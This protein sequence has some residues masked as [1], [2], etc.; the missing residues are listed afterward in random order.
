MLALV[1]AGGVATA[2]ASSSQSRAETFGLATSA[3]VAQAIESGG[4]ISDPQLT[5]PAVAEELPRSDIG[6][7]EA[8]DLLEGVFE[9][10]LDQFNGEAEGGEAE[11][12]LSPTVALVPSEEDQPATQSSPPPSGSGPE[13]PEEVDAETQRAAEKVLISEGKPPSAANAVAGV[14][15][16]ADEIGPVLAESAL[17]QSTVPLRAEG[18]T[19]HQEA[20]DLS[21]EHSSGELQPANPLVEVGVPDDLA[22][23]VQLG[24]AGVQIE[25]ADAPTGRAPSTVDDSVAFYPNVAPDT[26]FAVVPT[27]T[28]VE[29]LT[30]L[31]SSDAPRSQTLEL[32]L[33]AGAK[34]EATED[35]GAAVVTGEDTLVGVQAPTALDAGGESVPVSLEVSGDSLVLTVSPD[36]STSFPVLV[37]PLFQTYEW[38][39]EGTKT[40]QDGICSSSIEYHSYNPCN[41]REEWGSEGYSHAWPPPIK[42]DVQFWGTA[43]LYVEQGTPGLFIRSTDMLT[44]GDQG[45]WLYTVPRYFTDQENYGGATP[46]S[47]ISKMTLSNVLW[48]AF[49]AHP[50]PYLYMGLWSPNKSQWVSYYTH[51]GGAGHSVSDMAHPYEFTSGTWNGEQVTNQNTDAKVGYV[52][53]RATETQS[54]Q[55]TDVYVGSAAIRLED[56]DVPQQPIA[57]GPSQWVNQAASQIGFTAADTGLGVSSVTASTEQLGSNGQPLHSWKATYG[58]LGVADA[59]CPRKWLSSEA[60]HPALKVEPALL[61]AGEDFLNVVVEDPVGNKSSAASALVR[62]D[63]TAPTVSI[64]GT[65]TEQATLGTKRPA[66]MVKVNA[67]DGT[68]AASQSGAAKIAIQ[69]DGS[70]VKQSE[71][72][73][74]TQNCSLGLEWAI[75]SSKYVAGEHSIKVIATDAVGISTSEERKVTLKPSPPELSLS[76][77]M[78]EQASLGTTRPRYV[79]NVVAASQAGEPVAALTPSYLSSFGSYGT[80][81]GQFGHPADVAVDSSGSLWVVDEG[82]NRLQV[83][84]AKGEFVKSIGSSGSGNGQFRTPKSIA[85]AADG[86]FWVADSENSRLEKFSASG[87]FVKAVGSLG[88]GN[89]QF[90]RPEGI[91]IDAKGNIWVTDTYNYRVQELNSAGEFI[92][93]VNP[94]GLGA[95]EPT[96]IDA[97]PG[98]NVWVADWANN[99]VVEFNEAGGLVRS[100]GTQGTGNGQFNQPDAITIDSGGTVWV[101]DQNNGRIQGFN[102]SGEYLTQFGSKGAGAGQFT[103]S[104]PIGMAADAQGNLWIT[105]TNNNRVQRWVVPGSVPIYSS[106]LGASGTGNGQFSIPSGVAVGAE[107][108]LFVADTGNDR[109]EEFNQNGE[110]VKKFGSGQLNEPSAVAIAPSGHLWVSDTAG[111]RVVE[112]NEEGQ[113]LSSFTGTGAN[114]L[115]EPHGLAVDP[116]GKIWVVDT[117]SNRVEEFS[118]QGVLL[119]AFKGSGSLFWPTSIAAGPDGTIW[120]ADPIT[121]AVEKLGSDGSFKGQ[122]AA[123][124]GGFSNPSDIAVDESGEVW[125]AEYGSGG[126]D[127]FSSGGAFAGHFGAGGSGPGQFS[128]EVFRGGLAV[129]ARGNLWVGDTGNNR[130]QKW[131][132][133][134]SSAQVSTEVF[135][136]GKRVQAAAAGCTSEHCPIAKQWT[137]EAPGNEGSHTVLVKATDGLGN[138]NSK[139]LSIGVQK[140]TTKPTIEAGGSLI[141]APEGW[142]EQDG[143]GVNALAKDAGSGATSI[144]LKIDGKQAAATTPLD[145]PD[146]GCEAHLQQTINMAAY[147]G[148]AHP[149]EV[150][151][152]D[153]AGNTTVQNW[154]I[155][156]DPEGHISAAEAEDTLEAADGTSG[157]TVV[158]PTAES[159]SAEERADGNNPSLEN[160]GDQLESSGAADPS[161]IAKDPDEGFTV[162]LPDTSISATPVKVN[163]GATEMVVAANSAAIS[164]NTTP[165]VDAVVRP[166][167]NGVTTFQSIRNVS[168]PETFSWEVDLASGQTLKSLDPLDAGVFYAGGHEA[169]VISA[170]LAHDAVGTTVPTTISVSSGNTVT[171]TVEHQSGAFV[172]PVVGG[173]GWEGGFTTAIVAGPKDEQELREER[174]RIEQELR[175]Q[176]E[177]EW[178]HEAEAGS[179]DEPP[180]EGL[181]DIDPKEPHRPHLMRTIVDA[182]VLLDWSTRKRRS[183]ATTS[184][185]SQVSCDY[186]HAWEVGT[187]FWNGQEHVVGGFAW[188]GDTT[189]RCYTSDGPLFGSGPIR[190]GWAGP[191]PAPYG[192]GAHLNLWCN[193]HVSWFNITEIVDNHYN[194]QDH[195]Y[196]DGYQ[197]QHI[198]KYDPLLNP[199]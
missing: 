39:K 190:I 104:Y 80:G 187:W 38:M 15:V 143:Y 30:Q 168:A 54:T 134:G 195:L 55:N 150:I 51:E 61:P 96:G 90:N 129:D 176:A 28:G 72:G 74:S 13:A 148:G 149:A 64:S 49:S 191:N 193:F 57:T 23:G 182:P 88:S 56:K 46:T 95:I 29:T 35:G 99:R 159:I 44:A 89:G 91:A 122:L 198:H 153:G 180:G 32:D 41:N 167:Y 165:N 142:V 60:G 2:L 47:Y 186:W 6:R 3:D 36:S 12:Y 37:D 173:T 199:E 124:P 117:W 26:D 119:G 154:T 10:V 112:Y 69:F 100:F 73:C 94:S 172:Y 63:H 68:S 62:V 151:A 114:K 141:N 164:G 106:S 113:L 128:F 93:V 92:K 192:Y 77:T 105:D 156:V 75:E 65:A 118:P 22:E 162:A 45:N 126:I 97:G 196:G 78:S 5:N 84:N 20:V 177:R 110:F 53:I 9:P 127:R 123:P 116:S 58:C 11:R 140:D 147:D 70:A 109:I 33:P 25:L 16:S 185:C 50:S 40:W 31:R 48:Q 83:V 18:S 189:S 145:C 132:V 194:M 152:K 139:S 52:G 66:Y 71:P 144:E 42:P 8:L 197:G 4:S 27:T 138:T 98:G 87:A 155:N 79:L 135:L 85:F 34:L 43:P 19:G 136:D 163:P 146:G 131:K 76:G 188:Q 170:E 115:G 101:G 103:F 121:N 102:Q 158:A 160:A 157:S 14:W 86:S 108:H 171:L 178:E 133:H 174:E 169:Y 17:V 59:A 183:K 179:G 120:V 21:L 181:E 107:G 81:N 161:A 1:L 111:G 67:T 130:V 82:N 166:K 125:V 7:S 184:Y 137:L 175:E 24:E